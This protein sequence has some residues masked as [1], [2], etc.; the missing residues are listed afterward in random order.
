MTTGSFIEWF[1]EIFDIEKHAA[2]EPF[3][4]QL[5]ITGEGYKGSQNANKIVRK[6]LH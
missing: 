1:W 6:P 5:P 4:N 2:Q 3:E